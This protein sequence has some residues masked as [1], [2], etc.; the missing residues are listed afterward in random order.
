ML[1]IQKHKKNIRCPL[2][3]LKKC[4]TLSV[5]SGEKQ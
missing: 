3:H 5:A 2:T 4:A 1:D